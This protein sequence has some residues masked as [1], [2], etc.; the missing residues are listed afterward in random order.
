MSWNDLRHAFPPPALQGSRTA[1][2][3]TQFCTHAGPNRAKYWRM[4]PSC[5]PAVSTSGG[6]W[7]MK[8]ASSTM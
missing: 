4:F 8:L 5:L 7:L 2:Y 6:E 1:K 3:C